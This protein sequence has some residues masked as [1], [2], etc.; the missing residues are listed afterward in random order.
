MLKP[1]KARSATMTGSFLENLRIVAMDVEAF[2][3]V[4]RTLKVMG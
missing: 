1:L 2:R 3:S 4:K